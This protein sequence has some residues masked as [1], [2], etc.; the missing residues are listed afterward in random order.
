[1]L[2]E[3]SVLDKDFSHPFN[4]HDHLQ[5]FPL[6]RIFSI[7]NSLEYDE[8]PNYNEYIRILKGTLA[9]KGL[10]LDWVMDW[11]KPRAP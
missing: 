11:S 10:T 2:S 1:M 9:S 7:V 8:K 3:F 6:E 4:E 5:N